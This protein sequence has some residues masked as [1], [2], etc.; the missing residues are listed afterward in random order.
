MWPQSFFMVSLANLHVQPEALARYYVTLHWRWWIGHGQ[1]HEN[2]RDGPSLL[3]AAKTAG[4][5][6]NGCFR[7]LGFESDPGFDW[8][9][10]GILNGWGSLTRGVRTWRVDL[11]TNSGRQEEPVILISRLLLRMRRPYVASIGLDFPLR[12]K[13]MECT[14]RSLITRVSN[15]SP[16]NLDTR[17]LTICHVKLSQST[18]LELKAFE[19]P[20]VVAHT[21]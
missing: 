11:V 20:I 12:M 1:T 2:N 4:P 21:P 17:V 7:R 19:F 6:G 14:E 16:C 18:A 13:S 9:K 10:I 8:R 5:K 3:V 15:L